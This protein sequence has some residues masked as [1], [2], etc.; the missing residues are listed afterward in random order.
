[1]LFYFQEWNLSISVEVLSA[2]PRTGCV[3]NY[4]V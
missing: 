2:L 4:G 3:G 1:L